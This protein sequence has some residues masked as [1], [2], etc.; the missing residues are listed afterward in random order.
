MSLLMEI[1]L[2]GTGY[3]ISHEGLSLESYWNAYIISLNN[4]Q[5]Q[6]QYEYGGYSRLSAGSM[7]LSPELFASEWPPPV[8]AAITAYYTATN[9]AAK[10][11]MFQGT[12]HLQH[13]NDKTVS[14]EIDDNAYTAIIADTTAYDTNLGGFFTTMCGAGILN[15]T[16]D[17][18]YAGE[19]LPVKF[20][21][22][23]DIL[24]I[25]LA[26]L[27][28]AYNAHMFYIDEENSKLW[29]I[30]MIS[31]AGTTAYTEFDFFPVDYEYFKPTAEVRGP[32]YNRT[33]AYTY[34]RTLT[35][36]TDYE[37][38]QSD[39]EA[40]YDNII[41]VLNKPRA[42]FRIPFD[43]APPV[44]GTKLTWTDTRLAV[45]TDAEIAARSF[46]YNFVNEKITIEGDG[47]VAAT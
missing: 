33:S 43:S 15:L 39:I 9:E 14:Y 34:G 23:G 16:Y 6:L 2:N 20:T 7:V 25:E 28:A 40:A 24:A 30:D 12:A 31:D 46:D 4:V 42:R 5:R 29:L 44:P 26:S 21:Q 8:N 3:Q 17:N 22:S 27:V 36:S 1:T 41:T 45:S 37:D 18:T 38:T 19:A 35:L 32:T 11:E 10:V 13:F 47:A